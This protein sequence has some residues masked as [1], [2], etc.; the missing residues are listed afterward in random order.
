MRNLNLLKSAHLPFVLLFQSCHLPAMSH[1]HVFSCTLTG[2][3]L[4]H[5]Y[6]LLSFSSFL[7]IL[8]RHLSFLSILFCYFVCF[9]LFHCLVTSEMIPKMLKKSLLLND[10]PFGFISFFFSLNIQCF[11][12]TVLIGKFNTK[13]CFSSASFCLHFSTHLLT[14][15]NNYQVT[16]LNH[17][18]RGSWEN[19][20]VKCQ[21]LLVHY[22][23]VFMVLKF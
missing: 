12:V 2:N 9:W 13:V 5:L 23:T 11:L 8:D 20:W 16:L 6:Y 19:F 21:Q 15:R 14:R 3:T 10:N 22:F 7:Y 17:F 18:S 1:T 4:L